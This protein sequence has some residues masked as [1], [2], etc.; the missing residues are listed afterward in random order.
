MATETKRTKALVYTTTDAGDV[1]ETLTIDVAVTEGH[2]FA[3]DITAHPVEK[4]AAVTDHCRPQP[5]KVSYGEAW[6]T[7]HPFPAPG[8][9]QTTRKIN[10]ISLRTTSPATTE[11]LANKAYRLLLKWRNTGRLLTVVTSLDKF[12]N[13]MI[14]SLSIPRDKTTSEA[15]KFSLAFKKVRIVENRLSHVTVSKEKKAAKK[16]KTGAQTGSTAD[17]AP[18]KSKSELKDTANAVIK[19]FGSL[20]GG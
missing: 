13:M 11:N 8:A 15:L 6:V 12:E 20:T 4:G 1:E 9:A 19:K 17:K 2:D 5:D 16:V 3:N 14:E 18:L 10:G 7:N